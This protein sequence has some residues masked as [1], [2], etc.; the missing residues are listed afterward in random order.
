MKYL[1]YENFYI[2]TTLTPA[3]LTQKLEKEIEP[4]TQFGFKRVFY[5]SSPYYFRGC[6]LNDG[7][8]LYPLIFRKNSFIPFIKGVVEPY[9][10]G[11]K[12][13]VKMRL[14]LSMFVFA[15]VWFGPIITLGC[16]AIYQALYYGNYGI[17][18]FVPFGMVL[19]GYIMIL[20]GFKSESIPAKKKLLKLFEG[21]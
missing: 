6:L 19:F 7:F 10:N 4:D 9:L 18:S 11:S 21:E 14:H 8:E 13:Q 16:I 20:L 15:V 12:V 2:V 3:E 17:G 5:R 1:P